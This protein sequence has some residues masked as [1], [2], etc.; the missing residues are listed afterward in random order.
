MELDQLKSQINHKLSTDHSGRSDSDIAALLTR[1]T[2]SLVGKLK[3]SLQIE[4]ISCAAVILVFAYLGIAGPYAALRIYFSVFTVFALLFLGIIIYLLRRTNQ[5]SATTLPVK[6][7]LQTIVNIIED[8][9]KR[10]FQFTMAMIPICFV[11]AFYLGYQEPKN[12]APLNNLSVRFFS[13]TWK[14]VL[15]SAIYLPVLF[16][17]GYYFTKWYLRKLYGRFTEQLKACITELSED[18]N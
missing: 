9:S 2:N 15:F 6:S 16:I 5:L 14:I 3:R 13:E 1:K 8:F 12:I 17:G 4:I 11:F 7:N 10:Y 18:E